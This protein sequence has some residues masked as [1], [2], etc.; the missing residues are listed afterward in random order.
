[1]PITTVASATPGNLE[2]ELGWSGLAVDPLTEFERGY[3]EHRPR[4]KFR[5]FFVADSSDA[6]TMV[7]VGPND[8]VTSATKDFTSRW[9]EGVK[10]VVAPTVTLND[11][12]KREGVERIDFLN[13]D[14]ELAEPKALAGFDSRRFR[15]A[16]VCIEAHIEVR[17]QILDYFQQNGYVMLGK[18]LR[19]DPRNLYFVPASSLPAEAPPHVGEH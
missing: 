19:A 14:I 15:P 8:L 2:A 7:Y 9:G 11:L 5:A 16:L 18:Y 10:E 1:M 4:T 13:M 17:Q 6:S 12:L 3:R